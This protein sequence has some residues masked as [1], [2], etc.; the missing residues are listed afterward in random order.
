MCLRFLKIINGLSL[1][2]QVN[3]NQYDMWRFFEIK[4]FFEIVAIED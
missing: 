2:Y 4:E 1:N 3:F